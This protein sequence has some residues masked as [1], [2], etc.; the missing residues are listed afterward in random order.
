[1]T[2]RSKAE[3]FLGTASPAA[4]VLA[5]YGYVPPEMDGAIDRY[6]AAQ[7]CPLCGAYARR[8]NMDKGKRTICA[9]TGK[10]AQ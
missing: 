5:P 2:T 3:E 1:M 4:R 9:I 6:L 8:C 10:A 7:N